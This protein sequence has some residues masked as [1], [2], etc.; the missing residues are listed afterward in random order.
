[1]QKQNVF[2][3]LG[4]S[5]I[6]DHFLNSK[7]FLYICIYFAEIIFHYW[8][9]LALSSF[10]TWYSRPN[11]DPHTVFETADRGQF[12]V[13]NPALWSFTEFPDELIAQLVAITGI[14]LQLAWLAMQLMLEILWWNWPPSGFCLSL[15]LL[16]LVQL[17]EES[18]KRLYWLGASGQGESANLTYNCRV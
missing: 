14:Q 7:R 12:T 2:I 4:N 8:L 6:L 10:S 1:M 18:L 5:L 11:G 13:M 17:G 15:S 9:M 3:D 16:G